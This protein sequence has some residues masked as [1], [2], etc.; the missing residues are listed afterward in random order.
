[1]AKLSVDENVR[2]FGGKDTDWNRQFVVLALLKNKD[3]F[4][5]KYQEHER[6][7]A[8]T[9]RPWKATVLIHHLRN[10][11]LEI[12]VPADQPDLK[13][14]GW[15]PLTQRVLSSLGLDSGEEKKL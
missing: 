5:K 4:E 7:W 14:D 12:P 2:F 9:H 1:N 3:E 11:L 15:M 8:V 10:E 6:T 13:P